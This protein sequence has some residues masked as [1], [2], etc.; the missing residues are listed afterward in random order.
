M[1]TRHL[2]QIGKVKNLDKWVPHELTTNLKLSNK[3]SSLILHN[4][5]LDHIVTCNEKWILYNNQQ[6]PAQW[7]DRG[8]APKHFP[9]PTLHHKR[10]WSLF[11]G[12]MP[13]FTAAFWIPAKPWH[14]RSMLRDWWD[15]PKTAN[16]CSHHWSTERAQFFS[17]TMPDLHNQC[18]KTGLWRFSSSAIF[19][20]LLTN[21][22]PSS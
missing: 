13:I 2:K 8:E 6:W 7:L 18:F 11:G 3:L 20:W 16:A 19:T 21:L 17:T 1:A 12:V 4:N 10:S 22:T 9:K 15:A 5:E 14:L